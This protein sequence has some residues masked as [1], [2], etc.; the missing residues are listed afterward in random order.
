MSRFVIIVTLLRL[1]PS[2]WAQLAGVS[3]GGKT[4]LGSRL[5]IIIY[6]PHSVAI[7]GWDGMDGGRANWM[8]FPKW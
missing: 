1:F 3:G 8:T 2:C 5:I 4:Y 6:S 7:G